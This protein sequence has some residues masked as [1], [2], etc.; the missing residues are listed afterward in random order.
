MSEQT[1]AKPAGKGRPTPKRKDA[2]RARTGPV[3]TPPANR[4]EAAKQLR[5]KQAEN[6]KYVKQGNIT[7]DDSALMPRD[8]GPVR[9][10]VRD[11]VDTRRSLGFLLL[12]GAGATII[13][14]FTS[15]AELQAAALGVWV[16]TLIGVALDMA[17]AGRLISSSLRKAFP[18]ERR[19]G[20]LA[21]GLLRTTV[22]RRFRMPRPQVPRARLF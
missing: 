20:H 4:R 19:R 7:G 14:N 17:L 1:E 22:I 15:S 18:G 9:K 5:E 3:T 13:A 16:A 12:P 2:Q 10:L 21:Y 6:R 11:I 8:R